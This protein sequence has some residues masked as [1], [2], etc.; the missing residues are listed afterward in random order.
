[1][2]VTKW[3]MQLAAGHKAADNSTGVP[4]QEERMDYKNEI[5]SRQAFKTI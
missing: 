2:K 5:N 4:G 1:M 3:Q